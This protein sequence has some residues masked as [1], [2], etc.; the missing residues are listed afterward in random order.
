MQPGPDILRSRRLFSLHLQVAYDRLYPIGD[1]PNGR[2][3][4]APVD[5]GRFEGERLNGTVLP[6]GADWV[7]FR[8][9]GVMEIDVRTTLKTHDDALIYLHYRGMAHAEPENMQRFI[10]RETQ[11]YENVYVRTSLI[12]ETAAPAYSWLNKIIAVANGQRTESGPHYE[13][14][15]IL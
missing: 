5:G 1:G 4:I 10:R 12:F 2:R 3:L 6:D 15:E 11:P 13:V 7:R 9:D 14:F 8:Q